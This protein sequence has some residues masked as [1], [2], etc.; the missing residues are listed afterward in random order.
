MR[1]RDK[2]MIEKENERE[3]ELSFPSLYPFW[4]LHGLISH[5]LH[6]HQ[7]KIRSFAGLFLLQAITQRERPNVFSVSSTFYTCFI[8]QP[9]CGNLKSS[10]AS[11]VKVCVSVTGNMV[12]RQVWTLSVRL[13]ARVKSMA[14]GL[15][16]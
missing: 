2:E 1:E 15:R 11:V 12:Q 14:L 10:V 16:S 4:S 3:R 8:W 9:L 6:C 13:A 5:C 7:K